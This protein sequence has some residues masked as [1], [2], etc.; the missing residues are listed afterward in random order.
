M[1]IGVLGAGMIGKAIALDLIKYYSVTT[2]DNNEKNLTQ[3]KNSNNDIKIVQA[4]LLNTEHFYNW[5]NEF[6]IVVSAVPGFMGYNTLVTLIKTC[7]KIVDISFFSEDVLQL[8]QLAI[9]NNCTVITDIGVAPGMS[10]LILGRYNAEMK[11][12]LFKCFVGGL[13]KNPKPP[14]YYKAPFSPIDVIEEYTRKARLKING[15]VIVKS[16]LTDRE[17]IE[18]DNI[19]TLEAF[20]TDGLRSLL[21]TMPHIPTMIE[22]TLRYPNHLEPIL[23]LKEM[24]FFSKKKIE[25]DGTLISPL[26][27]TSKLLI[28]EW[29]IGEEEEEFT[30]MKVEIEGEKNGEAE[31]VMYTL[32]DT[33]NFETKTS[34]MARTTGYTCN[35]SVQLLLQD[36]F[37]K[38]GVFP[39]ELIGNDKN[40]F[41]FV[42]QYLKE[43]NVNWI[44]H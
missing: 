36:Q 8:N 22:K 5:F 14:F 2:F 31:K 4:D 18:F 3:L 19:G 42:M 12:N 23:L 24:G 32:F 17:F 33:F 35:A 20:N 26:Q 13:P 25:V 28:N 41:D 34:S 9:D 16:A 38:K 44:K 43:R 10:N 6:D 15:E 1:K 30:I 7:K 37:T 29:M 27:I 39:P 40:C 11:I 21:Y